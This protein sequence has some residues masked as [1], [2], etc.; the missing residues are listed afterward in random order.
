MAYVARFSLRFFCTAQHQVPMSRRS[1]RGNRWH[2]SDASFSE[3]LEKQV[4]KALLKIST[5]PNFLQFF[6]GCSVAGNE[7][8][9]I[10]HSCWRDMH[11]RVLSLHLFVELSS[12][13]PVQFFCRHIVTDVTARMSEALATHCGRCRSWELRWWQ[14]PSPPSVET[15]PQPPPDH[16]ARQNEPD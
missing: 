16:F 8:I 11:S 13:F 2:A 7:R 9:R 4:L 12:R 6:E 15:A 1:C 3:Q 14:P 5:V 10:I